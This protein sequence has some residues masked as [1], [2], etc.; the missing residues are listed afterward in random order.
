MW[1]WRTWQW[2]DR[3]VRT[4]HPEEWVGMFC[5]LRETPDMLCE[6]LPSSLSCEGRTNGDRFASRKWL[7]IFWIMQ[8]TDQE[9]MSQNDLGMSSLQLEEA[10][11]L[12]NS[13]QSEW[14]SCVGM[15]AAGLGS[16][17]HT[18]SSTNPFTCAISGSALYL[19]MWELLIQLRSSPESLLWGNG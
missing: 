8:L 4:R 10:F 6:R 2:W 17:A 12:Q 14:S 7:W 11:H 13:S 9:Q 16:L 18:T 5:V 15:R 1:T 19:A 3:G